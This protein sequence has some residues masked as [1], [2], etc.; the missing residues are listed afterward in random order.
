MLSSN[1]GKSGSHGV[2][3]MKQYL[4]DLECTLQSRNLKQPPVSLTGIRSPNFGRHELIF[5]IWV[6]TSSLG[7]K[8]ETAQLTHAYTQN[9]KP[10]SPRMPEDASKRLPCPRYA[11]ASKL[12]LGGIWGLV[13]NSGVLTCR[14]GYLVGDAPFEVL[15]EGPSFRFCVQSGRLSLLL[16]HDLPP[17]QHRQQSSCPSGKRK[18]AS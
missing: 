14:K 8:L 17:H 2:M 18:P 11:R 10:Y 15:Y 12:S 9:L 13:N 5:M 7:T 1:S 3:S 6:V 16:E 4:H